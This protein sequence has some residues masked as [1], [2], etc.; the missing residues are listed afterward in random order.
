M[1]LAVKVGTRA[2]EAARGRARVVE[3]VASV[4]A[5]EPVGVGT[6]LPGGFE[7]A[8]LLTLQ[9]AAGNR[10]VQRLL[11]PPVSRLIQR[12]NPA[13]RRLPLDQ[14]EALALAGQAKTDIDAALA[15]LAAASDPERRNTPDFIAQH[16]LLP[17]AL[18]PRHDS[19]VLGPRI[20]FFPGQN[21][22][23]GSFT[24]DPETT[25]NVGPQ[26]RGVWVRAR[27][28][29]DDD[30]ALTQGEIEERLVAAVS[31]ISHTKAAR[32]GQANTF[33]RYRARFNALFEVPPF[34]GMSSEFDPDLG[35]RGPRTERAKAVFE[36]IMADEASFL[37]AY[38]ANT[39]GIR[40]QIDAYTGPEGMN[41]VNSPRLQALRAAFFPFAVP[42]PSF[43]FPAFK[44][45]IEGASADLDESDREAVDRSN[46]WQRLINQHV[47]TE[48]QR[49]E[50]RAIIAGRGGLSSLVTNLIDLAGFIATWEEIVAFHTGAGFADVGS[51]TEAR[52]RHGAIQFAVKAGLPGE[53]TN[54]GLVI[55][56][57]GS[58]LR[59]GAL[60]STQEIRPFP[61]RCCR[62][63]ARLS[64][65]APATMPAEGDTL[66]VRLE[67]LGADR[68]TVLDTRDTVLTVQSDQP[69]TQ[70]QAEAAAVEDDAFLHDVSP[71][72]LLGQMI[73]MGG[74]A[75]NVADAIAGNVIKL[76]PLTVRHD[77]AA[78][79]AAVGGGADPSKHGFF[80]GTSYGPAPDPA[81]SFVDAATL[82]GR[83]EAFK[84][85]VVKRTFDAAAG[86]AGKVPDEKVI[87]TL[88]HE[89]VHSLDAQFWFSASADIENYKTEFRAYW[90][91]GG[92]GPPDQAT[93]PA[94]ADGCF[95]A[96]VDPSMPAPGP[97][98]PR[99]RKIFDHLYER[100]E[101]VKP[102][103]DNNVDGFRDKVDN[104]VAPDG[105]NLLVSMRLENLRMLID[106]WPGTGFAV[107]RAAVLV[108][109]AALTAEEKW[110]I[111]GN[112][113]WRDLVERKV[114]NPAQRARIKADLG[115]PIQ[116]EESESTVGSES[117]SGELVG[118]PTGAGGRHID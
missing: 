101:F 45:A 70:A 37:T 99:A 68:A 38:D 116:A 29:D 73:A 5:P 21:N 87:A 102:A 96:E 61:A 54:N 10:A 49:D 108:Q 111:H 98:S 53:Q 48:A 100:Y 105:I 86:A 74:V 41:R 69:F 11:H 65:A 4:R 57:R 52:Y 66:T 30:G 93:C 12:A 50:I 2:S 34:D 17:M 71:T 88:V 14:A 109:A 35:S 1:G 63:P 24:A 47:T 32:P 59:G 67:I 60:V 75:K 95:S 22:Y 6:A 118:T 115:I 27:T 20:H 56:L 82:G 106:G 83:N 8:Q 46:D 76:R 114:R 28:H 79:V 25:H 36:R 110:E 97:K 72:G 26:R 103:Y 23:T 81:R 44:T 42:V 7:P 77:S 64:A 92:F 31:E 90:M 91:D 94:D 85:L 112:R 15:S 3:R 104:Y 107:F 51:D 55:F 62:A 117:Q 19:P 113:A 78:F 13:D 84:D 33:D 58:V 9:R 89:G 40:E 39:N 43:Q 18:T 16:N 80:I